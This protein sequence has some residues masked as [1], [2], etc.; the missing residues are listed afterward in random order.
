MVP[1][2]DVE[3]GDLGKFLYEELGFL[4]LTAPEN[5]TH[6]VGSGNVAVAWPLGNLVHLSFDNFLV[7]L[8]GQ[9]DW[10]QTRVLGRDQSCAI[11]FLLRERELVLFDPLLSVVF[12]AGETEQR[13]L[14]VG[15]HCLLVDVHGLAAVFLDETLLN[16]R[17]QVGAPFLVYRIVVRI[18]LDW[19]VDLGLVAV[20]E[21]LGVAIGESARFCGVEDV[22]GEGEDLLE[23]VGV[24]EVASEGSDLNHGVVLCGVLLVDSLF[25]S[26]NKI[27]ALPRSKVNKTRSLS[28]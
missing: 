21:A 25:K 28:I 5:V 1:I 17:E 6:V 23:V 16:K 20:E 24:G 12:V 11:E 15:T 19:Q 26:V 7:V 3:V 10:L 18:V 2:S 8:K 22:V 9:K 4:R 27:G 13:A 14:G